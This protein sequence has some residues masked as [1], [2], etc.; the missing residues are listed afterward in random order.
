MAKRETY[1]MDFEVTDTFG[2]EA[3]YCW[4]K[5]ETREIECGAS[6]HA[7]SRRLRAFAG[8][9]GLKAR[10]HWYG[11]MM[12]IRPYGLCQVAFAHVRY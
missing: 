2:G 12:E 7:I 3:N 8:F 9:T 10:V 4:V 1:E 5:R 6:K 11:D